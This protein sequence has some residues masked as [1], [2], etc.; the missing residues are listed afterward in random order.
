MQ[1]VLLSRERRLLPTSPDEMISKKQMRNTVTLTPETDAAVECLGAGNPD[2]Q[3]S[4]SPKQPAP[5][6]AAL[7]GSDRCEAGGISVCAAAPVLALCRK[8]V[9]A[10]HDPRRPLHAY[11]G[12]VLALRVGSISEGAQLAIAGDGVGFRR[13]KELAAASRVHFAKPEALLSRDQKPSNSGEVQ[14]NQKPLPNLQY[15]AVSPTRAGGTEGK[16]KSE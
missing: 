13:R 10:G 1:Q 4:D 11:R 8:L 14:R 6:R 15:R 5:I 9:S 16:A 12:N 3:P 7:I 2:R